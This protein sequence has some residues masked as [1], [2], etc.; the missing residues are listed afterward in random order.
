MKITY[1]PQADALQF[2]FRTDRSWEDSVE[3]EEGVTA[4]LDGEGHI[5]GIEI[6]DAKERLG[7]DPL[8]CLSIVRLTEATCPDENT[9]GG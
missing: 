3:I 5:L 9:A 6:L 1:D 2:I 4:D 8:D 7:A